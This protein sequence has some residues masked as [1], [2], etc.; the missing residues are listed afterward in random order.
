MATLDSIDLTKARHQLVT[1]PSIWLCLIFLAGWVGK[2]WIAETVGV[3]TVEAHE[4]DIKSLV[5]KGNERDDAIKK[6]GDTVNTLALEIR[7]NW[8]Y[9]MIQ[10]AEADLADHV[11]NHDHDAPSWNYQKRQLDR[12]VKL[13]NE[14]K[15]CILNGN[16]NCASIQRQILQ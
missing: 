7:I 11:D 2:V 3:T 6:V 12:K 4:R 5:I 10:K 16:G 9:Q 14:Y 8:A 1:L 13:A 15:T